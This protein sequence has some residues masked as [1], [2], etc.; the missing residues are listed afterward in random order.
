MAPEYAEWFD[1]LRRRAEGIK[2]VC[3]VDFTYCYIKGNTR[4]LIRVS[5]LNDNSD[6]IFASETIS[7][8]LSQFQDWL[9]PQVK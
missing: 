7:G 9:A 6:R 2:E 4:Y 8:V 5:R 3:Q 1:Q